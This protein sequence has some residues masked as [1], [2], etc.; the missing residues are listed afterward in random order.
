MATVDQWGELCALIR[1]TGGLAKSPHVAE[2]YGYALRDGKRTLRS[3]HQLDEHRREDLIHDA[4]AK[5]L[6]Q[7]VSSETPKALFTVT[8]RR[9]AI[10]RFR[11]EART[12]RNEIADDKLVAHQA[13]G[14]PDS[15][16]VIDA[17][18]ALED[19]RRR[20]DN[21]L[22]PRERDVL[23][24]VAYGEDR[25]VIARQYDTTR[26]NIDQI[27]SRARRKLKREGQ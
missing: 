6:P 23:F 7:I 24:A 5:A 15:A 27:V 21:R 12:T 26:V 13:D 8:V 9:I 4:L 1:E 10:D 17:N 14:T 19:V 3:F 16:T 2:L 18:K 25:D 11:R 20:A 22:T